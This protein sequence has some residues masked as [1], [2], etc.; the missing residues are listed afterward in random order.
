MRQDCDTQKHF[1]GS[2][3]IFVNNYQSNDIISFSMD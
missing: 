1:S 2:G 3:A